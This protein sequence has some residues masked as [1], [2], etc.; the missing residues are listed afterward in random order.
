VWVV[1][2]LGNPGREYARTRHN[3]GFEVVDALATRSAARFGRGDGDFDAALV[4]WPASDAL[5]VKPRTYVNRSGRV[6]HQ[7]AARPDFE[8]A[9]M[10]VVVDDVALPFGRL[11]L[12][13]AGSAGGH[14]GLKSIVETLGDGGFPRL[15][16]GV[17]A[18]PPGIDLADWVLGPFTAD[19]QPA[20][21][22]FV[23]RAADA[24]ERIVELGVEAAI[25]VVNAAAP[26]A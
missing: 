5:L 13:A 19:E 1:L 8:L 2:G 20:V 25:P 21:P 23:A 18:Q 22:A 9:R 17:G 26:P 3:L 14:N 15:R 7:L 4:R 6:V 11:R 10:L 12:R 16:L 24:V